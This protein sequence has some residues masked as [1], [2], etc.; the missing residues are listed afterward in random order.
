MAYSE[1]GSGP[2]IVLVHGVLT[3]YRYWQ[4][5][6]DAWAP[7]FHV[8]AV[9]LRH[10]YPEKWQ[11]T[12]DDFSV[13]Q[14]AKDL[15]AFIETLGTPVYLLG[16]SYGGGVA[17]QTALARP[18]LVKK[19]VLDEGGVISSP[20]GSANSAKRAEATA[21][22]YKAG[23]MEG[24]INYSID[25]INGAGTWGKL[26]EPAREVVRDNA[27]TIVGIGMVP[28]PVITCVE[29][30]SLK[31]PVLLV[32]GEYTTAGYKRAL[33]IQSGCLPSAKR[34]TIPKAGHPSAYMNPGA[35]NDAVGAFFSSP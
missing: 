31:M 22:Y 24:G 34:V 7:H 15:T 6:L 35:F 17:Y 19:L 30:G 9:S 3:D 16:W 21:A 27:W 11:G 1:K 32:Q 29:F 20:D 10:F 26:P 25:S 5:E 4:P 12:G 18:D 8:I 2:I 28:P 13:Q 23:D 14:N 33:D